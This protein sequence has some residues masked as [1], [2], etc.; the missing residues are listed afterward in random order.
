MTSGNKDSQLTGAKLSWASGFRRTQLSLGLWGLIL[1]TGGLL[2]NV[3]ARAWGMEVMLGVW[4][5]LTLLGLSG[6]YWLAREM[7]DSGMLF[8]WGATMTLGFLLTL[9]LI[10]LIGSGGRTYISAGWHLVFAVGYLIT[11]YTMDRRLWWL[12]GWELL[13]AIVMLFLLNVWPAPPAGQGTRSSSNEFNIR[14]NQGLILGLSSGL[15]LLLAALPLW[16]ER[17]D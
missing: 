9:A 15:P 7:L 8:V 4:A 2:H 12:A 17:Y 16:K 11:G 3:Y 5:G 14:N 13:W 6:S 10:Y 1:I